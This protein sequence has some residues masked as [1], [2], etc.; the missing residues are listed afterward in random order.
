M[1]ITNNWLSS[2]R[3]WSQESAWKDFH[4]SQACPMYISR[5]S[6]PN[7]QSAYNSEKVLILLS[8]PFF[9]MHTEVHELPSGVFRQIKLPCPLGVMNMSLHVMFGKSS[10]KS[11]SQEK[12]FNSMTLK[13]VRLVSSQVEASPLGG[14]PTL[15]LSALSQCGL[16]CLTR[17]TLF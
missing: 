8:F 1:F 12:S 15:L 10:V 13:N 11:K 9:I 5:M 7:P 2:S 17:L 14:L 3:I 16:G 4:E 6:S